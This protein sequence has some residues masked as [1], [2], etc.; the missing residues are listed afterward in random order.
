MH[1]PGFADESVAARLR[2]DG[3]VRIPQLFSPDESRDLVDVFRR[4]STEY[5]IDV[6]DHWFPTILLPDERA[7]AMI[8][9]EAGPIVHPRLARLVDPASFSPVRTDFSVKPPS[10]LSEL[11][12]HQDFS[13]VDERRWTALYFWIPLVDTDDRNGTLH[14]L[15]GSHRFA[16]DVRSRTV[17][18]CFDG[19][20][21]EVRGASIGLEC[22]A[23]D[24]VLMVSGVVH[25]SPPNRSQSLRL[26]CHGL[27]KPPAAPL[28]YFYAD[29]L[30]S[31]DEVEMYEV[32]I[33]RYISLTLGDCP[34][35][36][37]V[38]LGTRSRPPEQMTPERLAAGLRSV[39][40]G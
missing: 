23:G 7:R 31:D 3:Y 33:D 39:A 5:D 21:D 12:P 26:A 8:T 36:S 11:G 14:V 25:Y 34:R 22:E 1:L 15:P 40:L 17:P 10:E 9:R 4:T 38:P 19:V 13:V 30:T 6:G 28:V 32:D 24:V 27:L 2:D 16:N 20:L 18:A 37:A 29:E 35:G